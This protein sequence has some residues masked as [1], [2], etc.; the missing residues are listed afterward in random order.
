MIYHVVINWCFLP[1]SPALR[2]VLEG[3]RRVLTGCR[4]S[5]I[6]DVARAFGG[7]KFCQL[8]VDVYGKSFCVC[9]LEK[10]ELL[11]VLQYIKQNVSLTII[12]NVK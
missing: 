3:V 10:E 4:G 8:R 5:Q 12:S 2:D 6:A 11:E 1:Q 9:C 7:R